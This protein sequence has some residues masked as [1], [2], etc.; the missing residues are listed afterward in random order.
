MILVALF[1]HVVIGGVVLTYAPPS[2]LQPSGF[3]I[4]DLE[5]RI[6]ASDRLNIGAKLL[7]TPR[8]SGYLL[9]SKYVVVY[10]E[11]NWVGSA[12]VYHLVVVD[13]VT[14]HLLPPVWPSV[15]GAG[16]EAAC[17]RSVEQGSFFV[18]GQLL[19]LQ[20]SPESR[21]NGV[22]TCSI[23][24]G[25][26]S[27]SLGLPDLPISQFIASILWVSR[28]RTLYV[29]FRYQDDVN[30]SPTSMIAFWSAST[31]WSYFPLGGL[32]LSV[33][34]PPRIMA[35]SN[36]IVMHQDVYNPINDPTVQSL[37]CPPSS[38]MI[39]PILGLPSLTRQ[40][41]W[42]KTKNFA[43]NTTSAAPA[44]ATLTYVY[45]PLRELATNLFRI[46]RTQ[47]FPDISE[48]VTFNFNSLVGS[49][50]LI[51]L[52]SAQDF[53]FCSASDA[54]ST[55][56]L[57]LQQKEWVIETVITT[58]RC[59]VRGLADF[60]MGSQPFVQATPE[61]DAFFWL[62]T[63]PSFDHN[64]QVNIS[65]FKFFRDT[66]TIQEM[67]IKELY[68]AAK[69]DDM[70]VVGNDVWIS[71]NFLAVE[72]VFS[73][74]RYDASAGMVLWNPQL[75]EWT[76]TPGIEGDTLECSVQGGSR[77]WVPYVLQSSRHGVGAMWLACYD[78][79]LSKWFYFNPAM[80]VN[81][82]VPLI[83]SSKMLFGDDGYMYQAW[84]S[85]EGK[86]VVRWLPPADFTNIQNTVN[87]WEIWARFPMH[88]DGALF[89]NLHFFGKALWVVGDFRYH[90]PDGSYV[91][92]HIIRFDRMTRQVMPV[93]TF[94][95]VASC[96]DVGHAF[97][98]SV[99]T[100][101]VGGT[102]HA[103]AS[104]ESVSN[105]LGFDEEGNIT[106]T[107]TSL[108][109]PPS[110][111]SVKQLFF[112]T[113]KRTM[114][115]ISRDPR[116]LYATFSS[117]MSIFQEGTTYPDP[118]VQSQFFDIYYASIIDVT[119]FEATWAIILLVGL[120][121]LWIGGSLTLLFLIWNRGAL[122]NA[123]RY[124]EIPDYGSH[125]VLTN[126]DA[127]M[128][129]VDV[130]K[131][132]PEKV[133]LGMII[134][135]GGQGLVRR[136]TYEGKVYAAKAVLD[137]APSVFGKFLQEIKLLA[138]VKHPNVVEFFGILVKEDNL[139]MLTELMDTDLAAILSNLDEKTKL[140]ISMDI[141]SA[142]AFLH[143]FQPPILH[144][145]LKP[146][147]I[148]VARDGRVKLSDFGVSRL[149]ADSETKAANMTRDAGTVLYMAPEVWMENSSY[150][151]AC[152][153]YSYGLLLIELWTGQ[154][155]FYPA[156]VTWMLEFLELVRTKQI[157]PAVNQLPPTC[158]E[159]LKAIISRCVSFVPEERPSFRSITSKMKKWVL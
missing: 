39:P 63:P 43:P 118:S 22:A 150:G 132:D 126:M 148:L 144:R 95:G 93:D 77:L 109:A 25:C 26:T 119:L 14:G 51:T 27:I 9:S 58:P 100:L 61:A 34:Y 28:V 12:D 154:N 59:S 82:T 116:H 120:T 78:V 2:D 85:F 79:D 17:W 62:C 16:I 106:A 40:P 44:V 56:I 70:C 46:F 3:G 151:T 107:T 48:E 7:T 76:Q 113:S 153:V 15:F 67:G 6:F 42:V 30:S 105:L 114:V 32:S 125:G 96:S 104:G 52:F 29:L 31:G 155:P 159:E 87:P 157:V 74:I 57:S 71:G 122:R 142:M 90:N 133:E 121:L 145:D 101:W 123:F 45:V 38:D 60:P 69:V 11:F 158:P 84:N 55:T 128:A 117:G 136:A 33:T 21:L 35:S 65:L 127:I 86:L 131:L 20:S 64:N 23:T 138:S 49:N 124:I 99:D 129:D 53:V 36:W 75:N 50:F 149:M 147:N 94:K 72:D 102:I 134:G 89:R 10:G 91:L 140:Q 108:R 146:G 66:K 4:F 137:L 24:G 141:A 5:S 8:V 103:L 18:V 19:G 156:D 92:D 68:A 13:A 110:S 54:T 112:S 81:T 80:P 135:Q 98:T 130:A 97:G 47:V 139:Y 73:G 41:C 152:D 111:L 143:S 83:G 37:F 88:V 1:F 115:V